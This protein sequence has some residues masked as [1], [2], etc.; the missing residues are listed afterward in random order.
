MKIEFNLCDFDM[1]WH[2][3]AEI[4]RDEKWFNE[5]FPAWRLEPMKGQKTL[6]SLTNFYWVGDNKI[7]ALVAY[8]L[9]KNTGYKVGLFWDT[10]EHQISGEFWGCVIATNYK[11][12]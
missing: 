11:Q 10:A 4:K 5:S 12:P 2:T 3:G 7:Q 8:K 6:E 1:F 9:L